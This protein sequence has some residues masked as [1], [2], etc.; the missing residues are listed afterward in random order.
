MASE[1]IKQVRERRQI[2]L[3]EWKA[4][5]VE[6]FGEKVKDWVFEC[7]SCHETQTLKDFV[8]A[9]VENPDTV[10]YFSCIGRWVEGRGCDWT[11]GGLL[12]IHTTEVI[13]EDGHKV[14]VFEW[15]KADVGT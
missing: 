9:E 3:D 1:P 15:G 12:Q 4:E 5:A 7:A 8:D 10:F 11:L 2:S 6:K 13:S 14:P